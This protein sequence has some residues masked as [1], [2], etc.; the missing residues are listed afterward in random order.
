MK[1]AF[2]VLML[3]V[4]PLAASLAAEPAEQLFRQGYN[5]HL[6]K[7]FSEAERY[8]ERGLTAGDPNSLEVARIFKFRGLLFETQGRTQEAEHDFL[9]ALTVEERLSGAEGDLANTLQLYGRL[10]RSAGRV[11]EAEALE[12]RAAKLRTEHLRTLANKGRCSSADPVVSMK[13]R[14]GMFSPVVFEQ[15][16]PVYTDLARLAKL[17][18]AVVVYFEVATDGKIC[19]V[20]VIKPLG[21][22]LDENAMEAVKNWRFEPGAR[23]GYAVHV[24]ATTEVNF[25]L[26]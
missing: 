14:E 5:A 18:G 24:G 1:S 9:S 21:L 17:Q 4:L 25:R 22:G 8:Y 20:R 13:N 7:R 16:E 6:A 12:I 26:Q 3:G 15:Q 23:F 10:L 11:P 2:G 19:N